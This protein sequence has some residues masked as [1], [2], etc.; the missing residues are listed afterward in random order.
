MNNKNAKLGYIFFCLMGHS[1]A[2]NGEPEGP[3]PH[4]NDVEI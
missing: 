1:G 3:G 4:R 2:A